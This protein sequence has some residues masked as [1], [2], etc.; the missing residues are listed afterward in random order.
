MHNIQ[1]VTVFSALLH[2]NG[3]LTWSW[4]QQELC[5]SYTNIPKLSFCNQDVSENVHL[6]WFNFWCKVNTHSH[7]HTHTFLLCF[8]F[9]LPF[10]RLQWWCVKLVLSACSVFCLFCYFDN[11]KFPVI[12]TCHRLIS[13]DCENAGLY[14]DYSFCL[15]LHFFAPIITPNRFCRSDLGGEQVWKSST[16]SYSW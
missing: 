14:Q 6:V 13:V 9:W 10:Q 8:C 5:E 4:M 11:I 7:T 15:R 12:N 1:W 3:L 2:D 16:T